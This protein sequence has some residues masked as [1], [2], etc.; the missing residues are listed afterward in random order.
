MKKKILAVV[1]SLTLV[2]GITACGSTNQEAA[3]EP[4]PTEEAADGEAPQEETVEEQEPAAEVEEAEVEEFNP[5]TETDTITY[6]ELEEKFGPVPEVTGEVT[7]GGILKNN[8]NEA[9]L[10]MAD[11]MEKAAEDFGISVDIQATRTETDTA[12]QLSIA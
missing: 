9:W 7:I 12:G 11:G 10:T 1:M 5:D 6:A 4:T 3:N 8:A 2:M